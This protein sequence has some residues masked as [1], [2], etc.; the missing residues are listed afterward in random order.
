M[1]RGDFLIPQ[2]TQTNFNVSG[3]GLTEFNRSIH[4]CVLETTYEP[5]P[6]NPCRRV[7]LAYILGNVVCARLYPI[8]LTCPSVVPAVKLS[9][10]V[11][12]AVGEIEEYIR[13]EGWP[14]VPQDI[15]KV[16]AR[17]H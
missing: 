5:S 2:S 8:V 12:Q 3:C 1:H 14:A 9:G 16:R 11:K 17:S 6:V 15:M 13:R 4:S 10:Q 7:G